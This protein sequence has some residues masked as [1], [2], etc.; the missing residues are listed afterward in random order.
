MNIHLYPLIVARNDVY[1]IEINLSLMRNHNYLL[2]IVKF[3]PFKQVKVFY[4]HNVQSM[5]FIKKVINNINIIF[6]DF[7]I[8]DRDL[9]C[10]FYKK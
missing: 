3:T 8:D 7:F 6:R 1:I 4:I 10:L 9:R 2:A 5:V